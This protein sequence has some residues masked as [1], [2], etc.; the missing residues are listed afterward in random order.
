MHENWCNWCTRLNIYSL[1]YKPY[2]ISEWGYPRKLMPKKRLLVYTDGRSILVTAMHCDA[3][4]VCVFERNKLFRNV[5]CRYGIRND[6]TVRLSW[7]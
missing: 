7:E 3:N 1:I 2:L 5:E 6:D 4:W